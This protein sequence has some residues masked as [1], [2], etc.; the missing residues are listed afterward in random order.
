VLC[1]TYCR[2]NRQT[3]GFIISHTKQSQYNIHT[4]ER[5]KY[6]DA[7]NGDINVNSVL[8]L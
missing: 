6:T 1:Y 5:F 3:H 7:I 2:I 4:P 8:K